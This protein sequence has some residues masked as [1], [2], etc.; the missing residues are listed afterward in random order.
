M[1]KFLVEIYTSLGLT[2]GSSNLSNINLLENSVT[3][4]SSANSET[5]SR[6]PSL[7][8]INEIGAV[9][10]SSYKIDKITIIPEQFSSIKFNSLSEFMRK[11]I[12]QYQIGKWN[13]QSPSS[14]LLNLPLTEIKCEVGGNNNLCHICNSIS[15]TNTNITLDKLTFQIS[16]QNPPKIFNLKD[17]WPVYGADLAFKP[18]EGLEIRRL[19]QLGTEQEIQIVTT[20]ELP[21]I[22]TPQS[23][24]LS[25]DLLTSNEDLTATATP[26]ALNINKP[27]PTTPGPDLNKSLPLTPIDNLLNYNYN[28]IR[29]FES[30]STIWEGSET[31]SIQTNEV[32]YSYP[33]NNETRNAILGMISDIERREYGIN[34]NSN[35]NLTR[36]DTSD[37]L[38]NNNSNITRTNTEETLVN[39]QRV[40]LRTI[41]NDSLT[42]LT[43]QN[44]I[45]NL[46][47]R[48][49]RVLN[50]P[51]ISYSNS[52]L[53]LHYRSNSPV[54]MVRSSSESL[55]S[56]VDLNLNN[57]ID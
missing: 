41:N 15:K 14:I 21:S 8:S 13:N 25:H 45:S 10:E 23:L 37:T 54:S 55:L 24:I 33:E 5:I 53:G 51:R 30:N 56:N 7:D 52:S 16:N 44:I 43:D 49:P 46:S 27:L 11:E 34:N 6:V 2:G 19:L 12:L 29:N 50:S 22:P 26:R 20:K 17:Y 57:D 35:L 36:T 39:I 1:T 40:I 48:N 3:T 28:Y 31:S 9:D 47:D 4:V 32:S 42:E 18:E 38:V